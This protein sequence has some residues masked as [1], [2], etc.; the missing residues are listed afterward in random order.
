MSISHQKLPK[1]EIAFQNDF[2]ITYTSHQNFL[3]WKVFPFLVITKKGNLIPKWYLD[4]LYWPSKF[5]F[6]EMSCDLLI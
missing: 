3:F 2:W 5:T 4:H 1:K 6:L